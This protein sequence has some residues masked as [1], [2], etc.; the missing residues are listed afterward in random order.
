V[1]FIRT[2]KGLEWLLERET[3]VGKRLQGELSLTE[4]GRSLLGY[5]AAELEAPIAAFYTV[6]P[7]GTAVRRAAYAF[8]LV[9]APE[10]IPAGH[11]IIGQAIADARPHIVSV[12][13]DYVTVQSSL[14]SRRA[15][16]IV[17][18][19]A[20]DGDNT[21]A[22]LEFGFFGSVKPSALRL[23]DRIGEPV[24]VAV[25]S[26]TYRTSLQNLLEET[27][28]QAEEL[29]A[30]DEELRATNEELEERGR[31]MYETQRALQQQQAELE[32]S[33]DL[34][35]SRPLCS[36][37]GTMSLPGLKTRYG[38]AHR[39]RTMPTEP[40]PSSWPTCPTS[41]ERRSTAR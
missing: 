12:P 35:R 21:R 14:G 39:R 38:S 5:L 26:S 22:V 15:S 18:V 34:L 3:E 30:H 17:V 29:K 10:M 32:Q 13:P 19:P 11:G 36:S 7:D 24:A 27:R 23:F 2:R 33:N 16:Q 1:W 8:D 31:V 6:E 4:V 40:S 25:R 9:V 37:K 28:R 20:S 41:S